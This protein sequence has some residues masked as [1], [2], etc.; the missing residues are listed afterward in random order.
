VDENDEKPQQGVVG[1]DS[2]GMGKIMG[3][4]VLAPIWSEEDDWTVT[5]DELVTG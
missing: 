1:G 2:I 5:P 4:F 3:R